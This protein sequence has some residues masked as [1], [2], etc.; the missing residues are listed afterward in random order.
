MSCLIVTLEGNPDPEGNPYWVYALAGLSDGRLASGSD[1]GI[2]KIW[3]PVTGKLQ[4]TLEGHSGAVRALAVLPDGR[5][6]SGAAS[7]IMIWQL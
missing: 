5:L 2:I 3:D 4:A 7:T 1:D 6:A